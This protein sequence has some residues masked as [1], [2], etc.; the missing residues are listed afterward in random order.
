MRG[1]RY[2]LAFILKEKSDLSTCA[3]VKGARGPRGLQN[4]CAA[5]WWWVGSTPIRLRHL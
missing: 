4:R 3:E 2:Q 5:E 1:N